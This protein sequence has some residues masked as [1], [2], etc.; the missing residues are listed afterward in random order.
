MSELRLGTPTNKTARAFVIVAVVILSALAGVLVYRLFY[1]DDYPA[2]A[3]K[4]RPKAV[5]LTPQQEAILPEWGRQI[6]RLSSE[7]KWQ[8]LSQMHDRDAIAALVLDGIDGK[9]V[10][11]TLDEAI[12][13]AVSYKTG[14]F[15]A[16]ACGHPVHFLRVCT[17][18]GFPAVTLRIDYENPFI[19][20]M[21]V[22]LQP[23]GEQFKIIDVYSYLSGEC[24][25]EDFRCNMVPVFIARNLEGIS[26]WLDNWNLRKSDAEYLLTLIKA[27][28]K[29]EEEEILAVCDQA[30]DHLRRNRLVFFTRIKALQRLSLNNPRYERLSFEALLNPPP[31][32]NT[33]HVLELLL[34]PKLLAAADYQTADDAM[35][36]VMAVIGDDAHLMCMRAEIKFK[37]GELEAARALLR[38]AAELEPDLSLLREMKRELKFPQKNEC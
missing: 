13:F 31:M 16:P 19:G 32:P 37:L 26:N 7:D 12:R 18:A 23:A 9:E 1:E 21:D 30:P 14:G 29:E 17:R 3:V 22:L 5:Q 24:R 35:E 4:P 36:K 6:A 34:V 20:Y 11:R 33:P 27:R 28:R 25:T 10:R 2:P 8:E 15:L 38:R